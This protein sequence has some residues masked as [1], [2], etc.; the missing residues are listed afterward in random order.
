MKNV[1]ITR[2]HVSG[3]EKFKADIDILVSIVY[4]RLRFPWEFRQ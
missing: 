3:V 2:S 1:F 4:A